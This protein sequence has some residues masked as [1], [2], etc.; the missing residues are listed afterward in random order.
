MRYAIGIDLGTTTLSVLAL[1]LDSGNIPVQRT[2]FH[3]A[4]TS[5]PRTQRRAELSLERALPL[6]ADILDDLLVQGAIAARDVC[7]IGVTGQQHGLALLDATGRPVA[8][9]ITWQDQRGEELYR[10][11]SETYVQRLIALAGGR[12]AFEPMGCLPATG[13]LGTT[14]FWLSQNQALPP[15]AACA[16]FI[17]DAV[18]AYLTGHLPPTDPTDG[19]SSGL[20]NIQA[21]DWDW[22]VILRLGLPRG[23]FP[24]IAESGS[25]VGML[26][27]DL[28]RRWRVP[29][30]TPVGV[31]L[32]DNQASFVGSVRQPADGVLVNI[33]TG[34][35]VSAW[36]PTLARLPDCDTRCFPGGGYLLV[37]AALFGGTTYA[38]LRDFYRAVGMAFFGASGQ[39]EL[40]DRMTELASAVPPDAEG[41]RCQPLFAGTR[42]DPLVRAA[43]SGLSASTLTPAHLTRALLEGMAEGFYALYDEMRPITGERAHLIGSGNA[44]LRNPLLR[45]LL[46]E[47]FGRP[48]QVAPSI[49][50]AAVGA[51]LV[52][53]I[54]CGSLS[55]WQVAASLL[56][57]GEGKPD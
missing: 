6:L 50:T 43:F 38:V 14:L 36:T 45:Q 25:V 5:V 31:A 2:V 49:E 37:G 27:A 40:Y 47:R 46:S 51:A 39:E 11:H 42:A 15:E 18:V 30:D 54:G 48:M 12:A 22:D 1:D 10:G 9:A 19:G 21:R 56:P 24:P 20:M 13:Y 29:T 52:A 33:G 17:P 7:C 53:A 26:R 28:A 16:C 57:G 55:G 41:V 44:I 34:G 8:P 3:D 23:L 32:G 4:G 35:Q